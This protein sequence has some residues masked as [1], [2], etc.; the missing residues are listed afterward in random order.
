[1]MVAAGLP[2]RAGTEALTI[3]LAASPTSFDPHYHAHAPSYAQHR[4]VFEPLLTRRA[5]LTLEPTLARSWEPLPSGDG[6]VFQIDPAARFQDG[7]PVTAADAAASLERAASMPN[8]PGRWTPF[9]ADIARV[10][11]V[12]S[13]TLRIRTHGAAPMLPG[14]LPTILI[15]PERIARGAN[16]ADFNTGAAAIGSGPYRLSR[17]CAGECLTLTRDPGWWQSSRVLA[18][19]WHRIELRIVSQDAARVTALLSGAVDAIE[20]V[21]PRDAARIA[22]DPRFHLARV[23]SARLV[24]LAPSQGETAPGLTDARGTTPARNPLRDVRVRRA[25]SM[26]I[27]RDALVS[28]VMEGRASAAGQFLPPDQPASVPDLPP[29]AHRPD[30][31]RRLLAAAGWPDGFRLVLSGPNDRLP[32]DERILQAVAQMWERVGIRVAVQ[33]MPAVAYFPRFVRGEFGLGLSS[34]SGT[35]GEPNTFLVALL[36][37]RDRQRGRGSMNPTGYANPRL[38]ALIDRALATAEAPARYAAWAEAT[39]LALVEDQAILP[40]LHLVNIWGMRRGLDYEARADELTMAM[41]FRP[42][43]P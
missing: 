18:Q 1:M 21:P 34:W 22:A 9:L 10:E 42:T 37:T 7:T 38:D 4:Q 14:S 30:E 41:G 19:H 12:D 3:G 15:V 31:A 27:N 8:S 32:N 43:A 35:S 26:A 13:G 36:A 28:Q 20:A 23:R 33:T 16:T 6:W 5:D 40:L 25:L 24:Y 11:V 39:R 29:D 17:Y 2:A